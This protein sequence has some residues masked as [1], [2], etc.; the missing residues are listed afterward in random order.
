M[1]IFSEN[2][3]Q[4]NNLSNSGLTVLLLK[5]AFPVISLLSEKNQHMCNTSVASVAS[6][7]RTK[8][9]LCHSSSA[10]DP[11]GLREKWVKQFCLT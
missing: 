11:E 9:K 10:L 6:S 1:H 8:K 2:E 7:Y 5:S 3:A 4:S